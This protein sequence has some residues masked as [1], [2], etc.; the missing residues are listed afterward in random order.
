[1]YGALAVLSGL[2]LTLS[3]ARADVPSDPA[4]TEAESWAWSQITAGQI[5]D[6]D[7]RCHA[8]TVSQADEAVWNDTCRTVRGFIVEQ[9]L[10][11]APWRDAIE[12]Q[13]LRM[14][15]ARVVGSID[16]A[17]AHIASAVIVARSHIEGDVQLAHAQLGSLLAL[18]GSVVTGRIDGPAMVSESDVS[19]AD[20]RQLGTQDGRIGVIDTHEAVSL[21]DARIKGSVYLNGGHFQ[22]VVDLRGTHI[23]EE[24]QTSGADFKAALFAGS[25]QIGVNLSVNATRFEGDALFPNSTIGGL[26]DASKSTF[27]GE[28]NL[29][30]SHVAGDVFVSGLPAANGVDISGT[31]VG[32]YVTLAGSSSK[33]PVNATNTQVAGDFIFDKDADD[34]EGHINGAIT[35]SGARVGRD[36]LMVRSGFRGPVQ[37]R[38]THV[39][40]NVR[41]DG[42][43]FAGDLDML[44]MHADGDVRLPGARVAGDF[45]ASN[46][47]VKQDLALTDGAH[48]SGSLN[49]TDAHVA[50]S[51]HMERATF[52]KGIT[53]P[54]AKIDG[55]MFLN[56]STFGAAVVLDGAHIG[57]DLDLTGVSISQLDLTR[58]TVDGSLVVNA[59]TTW[60]PPATLEAHQLSLVNAKVGGIQDGAVG[61]LKACPTDKHPPPSGNGWP[62]GRTVEFDGFTYGHLGSSASGEGSDMR[63]RDLCWWRW[64]LERDRDFSSQ[65]YIQ[66]ASVMAAHGD[67][68]NAAKVLYYGR[69][70][71]TQM[72]WE[73]GNYPRWML[74]AALNVVT[75]Y[76]IGTYTFR[77]LS[78]IIALTVV[79]VVLLKRS[80]GARQKPL[81]WRAGASLTRV[82]PGVEI[83]REFTDFFDDPKRQRLKDWQ[84]VV[85]SAFVVIGWVL[86]L[87]LVAAMTGLTQHS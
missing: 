4:W 85:F 11:R 18:D 55:D 29:V 75:G 16:L 62:M 28:F 35:L 59:R 79:G 23:D 58:A 67:Q 13:G 43:G 80:P 25:M 84:V 14:I 30:D 78:W 27:G 83:N 19:F 48:F 24:V 86:G 44:A 51:V 53:A 40:G 57:G 73:A 49:V 9:M 34:E 42:A 33:G 6:F 74:L 12:H 10:T 21:R 50:N 70:R 1:M 8:S 69:V 72:A 47:D 66:L 2:L 5:A 82:L 56:D 37:L 61:K 45:V 68:D 38:N 46:V 41:M 15:G 54:N 87:F 7:W 71:E 52:D 63:K 31:Q 39:V 3:V 65:P 17:N 76:G 32:G 77:A 64:W 26:V 22:K 20:G 36:L 81:L 60:Q